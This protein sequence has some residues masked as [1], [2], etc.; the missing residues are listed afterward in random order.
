MDVNKYKETAHL[1][2]LDN[3]GI[4]KDDIPFYLN[5]AH[6]YGREI[7]EIA[8]GT[9]RICL[10]LARSG[11]HVTGYD[12]SEDMIEI[13]KAKL[14]N[15]DVETQDR[16]DIFVADMTEYFSDKQFSLIIVPFRAFQL[17][18]E[19]NQQRKFLELVRKQLSDDGVFIINTYRPYGI[20]DESWVQ[21]EKEDWIIFDSKTKRN[22]RRTHIRRSIDL[23]KQITYPELI[24][25]IEESDGSVIK[26]V[27]NLAMK[28]YYEEQLRE[29]LISSGFTIK[30]QYGYYDYRPIENGPELIFVCNPKK[31]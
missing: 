2:D 16:A 20:L 21:D 4:V 18:T 17:L 30:E 26:H 31:G 11:L 1:Y 3:R 24:Y 12:L 10:A 5:Y 8:C 9:G 22:V 27:E 19:D 28:Y 25:Y 7:L 13:L 23:K 15:E 14:K 6:Q 29:L